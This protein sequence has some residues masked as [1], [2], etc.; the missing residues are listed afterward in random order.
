MFR[1]KR[2]TS[3]R[4]KAR[5]V[6]DFKKA[7]PRAKQINSD[8]YQIPIQTGRGILALQM[9]L[10]SNFP[11]A[12]P[13]FTA[14][15]PIRHHLFDSSMRMVAHRDLEN[16]NSR[17]RLDQLIKSIQADLIR[18]PPTFLSKSP[19]KFAPKPPAQ[20]PPQPP[21]AMPVNPVVRV[22]TVTP[23]VSQREPRP[24]NYVAPEADLKF[25]ML[26][27]FTTDELKSLIESEE[28]LE[29]L[30]SAL[31]AIVETEKKA[32]SLYASV[33]KLADKNLA[34]KK[35]F[36]ELSSDLKVLREKDAKLEDTLSKLIVEQQKILAVCVQ[37]YFLCLSDCMLF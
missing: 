29:H 32:S 15:T 12:R 2:G 28:K 19:S 30:I 6:L 11:M 34:E 27:G 1:T 25:S 37:E 9:D 22:N 35:S 7:F 5:Q 24:K 33:E 31:P 13:S 18:H 36:G 10:P 17:S 8:T 4:E 26:D 14:V 23:P 3:G 20:R 21:V 16:W